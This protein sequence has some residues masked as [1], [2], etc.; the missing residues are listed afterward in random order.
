MC[1]AICFTKGH[2][3]FGRNL[4]LEYHYDERVAITPRNF[5]FSFRRVPSLP[6]HHA[7]IGMATI[8]DGCPLYYDAVNEH[9]VC[10]AALSFPGSAAYKP[11]REGCDNV[12]PFE[13]IPWVLGQ[14]QSLGEVR[15]L[16]ARISLLGES[17]SAE[18]PL[19]PLHWMISAQGESIVVESMAD[20]L[21]VHDN[22][23]GVLT[24]NPSFPMQLHA[25]SDYRR[26]SPSQPENQF[27]PTL[28]LPA[29]SNGMGALGLPGDWSSASRFVRAAFVSA[30]AQCGN[31][32]AACVRQ[33]FHMLA[34]VAMPRGCVLIDGKPEITVYSACCNADTGVYAYT[35]YEN[36]RITAVDM[37]RENLDADAL[38]VYPLAEERSLFLQNEGS[39][40]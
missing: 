20:G 15:V 33:F 27:A 23:I 32:Q 7:I 30:N 12:T 25:L 6:N 4:D 17:F 9:G 11:L 35:T 1:T 3:Y 26:L 21:H 36:S 22:P 37:H 39:R 13:F 16:L 34:A 24:N 8:A 10:M 19:S 2:H 38:I 5:P 40:G 14:C 29:Y 18:L 28:D 31:T